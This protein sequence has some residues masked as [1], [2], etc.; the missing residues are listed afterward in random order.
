MVF[1]SG[2]FLILFLPITLGVYYNPFIKSREFR[3][4]WLA[5]M[6]IVFYAWGEPIYVF[7][8]LG[9]IIVNYFISKLMY[10]SNDAKT[11][12]IWLITSII[13]DIGVLFVFK[14]LAFA[15]S[16]FNDVFKIQI[17]V[18]ALTLPIGIS[19]YTFQI[20]SYM[21]DVY[22]KNDDPSDSLLN[23]ILYVSMFPQLVAGPIVRYG[24][25]HDEILGRS[26]NWDDIA[27][28]ISRFVIGLSKKVIIADAVAKI[29]DEMFGMVSYGRDLTVATAWLG[30]ISYTL[31][32]YFDFSGYSDMAIGLGRCFGFHFNENFDYPYIA[33]SVTDFW[34]RWHIS[35]T[36]WFREYI[37]IPMGGNRV[38]PV[39]HIWNLFVIWLLTGIWHGANWT[40]IVWGI[41]YFLLQLFEK[42]AFK[43]RKLGWFGHVY[44]MVVVTMCWVIFNSKTLNEAMRFLS[45]MI[46]KGTM[47]CDEVSLDYLC[48]SWKIIMLG[49]LCCIPW[50]RHDFYKKISNSGVF[51]V[52]EKVALV[53]VFLVSMAMVINSNYSPFIYYNF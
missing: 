41:I 4:I 31:Q 1:S 9:T 52:I 36:S 26:E 39:R 48:G 18:H 11:R 3:N 24:D 47:I 27:S 49:A 22:R 32:I 7:L 51:V 28:G 37:Y 15:T 12:R 5:L 14:Y 10:K 16:I 50:K 21:I 44:T 33:S 29:S 23:L 8:M 34:R 20:L 43:G 6:S 38:K 35:L 45:Y 53:V 25:I 30:A 13:V 2:V 40:F 46:G 17:E 42:Y 19:F